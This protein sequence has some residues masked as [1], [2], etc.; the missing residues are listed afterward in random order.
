MCEARGHQG[1]E[2]LSFIIVFLFV[3]LARL[4]LLGFKIIKNILNLYIQEVFGPQDRL[5]TAVCD[6][7]TGVCGG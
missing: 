3:Q 6:F 4:L 1:A 5:H 2:K 7:R